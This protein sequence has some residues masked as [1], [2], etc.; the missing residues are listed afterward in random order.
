MFHF[1]VC[2]EQ[3]RAFCLSPGGMGTLLG[4]LQAVQAQTGLRLEI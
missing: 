4:N 1:Y 3:G 2:T